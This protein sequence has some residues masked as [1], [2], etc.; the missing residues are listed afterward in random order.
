MDEVCDVIV[1]INLSNPSFQCDFITFLRN[2]NSA[3]QRMLAKTLDKDTKDSPLEICSYVGIS[4]LTKWCLDNE[5]DGYSHINY[6]KH[7]LYIACIHHHPDIVIILLS[8]KNKVY[9]KSEFYCKRL[10][11][12]CAS[13]KKNIVMQLLM[14]TVDIN[15]RYNTQDSTPLF[16]AC[17]RGHIEIVSVLLENKAG[18]IDINQHSSSLE[19]PLYIVCKKGHTAIVSLLLNHVADEVDVNKLTYEGESPF[20]AASEGGYTDIVDLLL[21]HAPKSKDLKPN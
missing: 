8:H 14:E 2:N 15:I 4:E 13:G 11:Q 6:M 16:V 10:H 18:E 20:H 9:D 17:E 21:A 7:P 5:A 12:A 3:K 1:N 19:S